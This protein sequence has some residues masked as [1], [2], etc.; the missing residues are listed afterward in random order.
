MFVVFR[1]LRPWPRAQLS[2]ILHVARIRQIHG[3]IFC[4]MC[5]TVSENPP[6]P[7]RSW[8]GRL[9]C[10]LLSL[11]GIFSFPTRFASLSRAPPLPSFPFKSCCILPPVWAVL[12]CACILLCV[13]VTRPSF[14]IYLA[15]TRY[16]KVQPIYPPDS[17]S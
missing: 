14:T 10:W 15:S 12:F 3:T 1:E 8:R 5:D 2:F 9:G 7:L 16:S 13:E 4:S 17:P 11:A 6:W